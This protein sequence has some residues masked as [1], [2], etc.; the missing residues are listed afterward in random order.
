[1]YRFCK[2]LPRKSPQISKQSDWPQ[3]IRSLSPL[4]TS[5]CNC[6]G[7]SRPGAGGLRAALWTDSQCCRANPPPH[8]RCPTE[9]RTPV[10]TA[11]HS[12]RREWA[13]LWRSFWPDCPGSRSGRALHRGPNPGAKTPRKKP[14]A[15][16][17]GPETETTN[18]L[19]I[20]ACQI[21]IIRYKIS[22]LRL[23]SKVQTMIKPITQEWQQ[24]PIVHWF[25]S[26]IQ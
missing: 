4:S 7:F 20:Q 24:W 13:I 25:T 21:I 6:R 16:A 11:L 9:G 19:S 14:S 2:T 15:A 23:R 1:M 22:R 17:S 5:P 3:A 26:E 8:S 18:T 10:M 12:L